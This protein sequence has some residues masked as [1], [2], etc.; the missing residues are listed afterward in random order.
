MACLLR[1]IYP[2]IPPKVEYSLTGDAKSLIPALEMI[3]KWGQRQK[4]KKSLRYREL[5]C[6]R[7]VR[8][9]LAGFVPPLPLTH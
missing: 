1:K 4:N 5:V 7:L 9:G 6:Q 8:L 2:E 3:Y